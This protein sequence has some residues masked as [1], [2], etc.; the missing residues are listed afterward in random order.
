MPLELSILYRGPL[1][2]CNYECSYCPFAKRHESA[3]ELAADRA[4]LARLV[5]WV[6]A[7]PREDRLSLFFTP[8]GEALVHRAYQ[9]ALVALSQLPQVHKVAIQTNLSTRLEWLDA[10]QVHKLGLWCTYHPTQAPRARFVA[11][12]QELDRR[13][14]PYSAGVVG[15]REH[16]DEIELLRR[17]LR[18]DVYLWINAFKQQADYYTPAEIARLAAIDPHFETNTVYHA[19]LGQACHTGERVISVDGAG[20]IRRCHFVPEPLGNLY[21]PDFVRS[22]AARPCPNQTCGCH[23]GYVHLEPLRLNDVYGGGLLERIPTGWSAG[24]AGAS[25]LHQVARL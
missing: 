8:W 21:D 7:R 17:E 20:V 2:S 14:V 11:Q 9:D 10:A 13:H 18:P 19:S 23:I 22:L 25:R 6:A 16:F 5:D 3:A 15:L 1:S 4:A 12:C 24:P